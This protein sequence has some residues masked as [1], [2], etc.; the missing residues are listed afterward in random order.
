MDETLKTQAPQWLL[1]RDGK[2]YGPMKS[3]QLKQLCE[4]G[5]IS[6]TDLIC[7]V[8][9]DRWIPAGEVQGLFSPP[10]QATAAALEETIR[11]IEEATAS[12]SHSADAYWKTIGSLFCIANLA[13]CGAFG[14]IKSPP[15]AVRSAEHMQKTMKQVQGEL[16]NINTELRNIK[17]RP[18]IE[19]AIRKGDIPNIPSIPRIPGV[20]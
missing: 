19:E 18:V 1:S 15:E 2:K 10:S 8:G 7:R 16:K 12:A 14:L 4:T 13:V 3:V 6:P 9:S 20:P 5:K 17:P 11:P